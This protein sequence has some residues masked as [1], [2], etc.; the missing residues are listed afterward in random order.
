MV[1]RAELTRHGDEA[2]TARARGGMPGQLGE[3]FAQ[4]SALG[5]LVTQG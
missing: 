5:N 1:G 2:L 3:R 4:R